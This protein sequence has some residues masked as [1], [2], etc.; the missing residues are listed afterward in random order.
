MKD[1]KTENVSANLTSRI[2]G[3]VFYSNAEYAAWVYECESRPTWDL[4]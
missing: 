1:F 3:K 4:L 2:N